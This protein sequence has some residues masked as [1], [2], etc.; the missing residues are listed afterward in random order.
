MRDR[1]QKLDDSFETAKAEPESAGP[2]SHD[3][4]QNDVLIRAQKEGRLDRLPDF[5]QRLY[6]VQKLVPIV[7][8][9][10]KEGVSASDV[11]AGSGLTQAEFSAASTRI[12]YR[13][14]IAV[15]TNAIRLSKDPAIGFRI[16]SRMHITSYGL[17]GYAVLSC[18][19]FREASEFGARYVTTIGP[20]FDFRFYSDTD[21]WRYQF[22]PVVSQDP[23]SD[24]YRF[25]LEL[26]LAAFLTF[27][28][29]L[30]GKHVVPSR[31]RIVYPP[32]A[33]AATYNEMFRCPILF[34]SEVN[35]VEHTAAD[36]ATPI[37]C[38]N[39]INLELGRRA[40][41]D[42]LK[43]MEIAG[44]FA[45]RVRQ[46]LLRIPG[47]FPSVEAIADELGLSARQLHRNL[48]AADTSYQKILD[49]ARMDLAI[50]YLRKTHITTDDIAVRLGFSEGAN[51]RHAFRKWT[52]KSTSEFR[53]K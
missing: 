8:A 1:I 49:E 50:A 34:N 45:A 4:P 36:L 39:P 20:A 40:C 42:V 3:A 24:L 46:A 5:D 23:T 52:G 11:L 29:D 48:R 26:T 31:L 15:Y 13:Q 30:Y 53:T 18:K 28:Y 47:Q 32:P 37:A 27:S 19:N 2:E 43:E 14:I 10:D 38:A 17:Y 44:G 35:E 7:E 12:S 33:H 21:W 41:E 6:P 25:A 51:F 22:V 16:G 9:L